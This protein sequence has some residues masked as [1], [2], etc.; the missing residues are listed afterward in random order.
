MRNVILNPIRIQNSHE[1]MKNSQMVV[2]VSGTSAWEAVLLYDKPVIHFAR[3][4][5]EIL[6][7][8]KTCDNLLSLSSLIN[9]E[10]KR[11]NKISKEER[12][13]RLICLINAIILDG[14]WIENPLSLGLTP[15]Q[16]TEME[17]TVNSKTI[18]KAIKKY[19]DESKQE[20]LDYV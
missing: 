16:P 7:L 14:F 4:F 12:K 20:S 1:I 2:V 8:S 10:Y 5:Y 6:G 13:R 15:I 17:I 18:A 3:E 9:S 11:I 19:M